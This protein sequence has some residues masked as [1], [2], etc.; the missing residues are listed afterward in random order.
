MYPFLFQFGPIPLPSYGV[1]AAITLVIAM[2]AVRRVA[3]VEGRAVAQHG[4]RV[5]FRV[6]HEVRADRHAEPLLREVQ[7]I[8]AIHG[9]VSL[10]E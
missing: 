2:L 4:R 10:P 1:F 5:R 3:V 7:V 8:A 9:C 6:Q